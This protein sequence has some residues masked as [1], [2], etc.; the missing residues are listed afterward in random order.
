M[1]IPILFEHFSTVLIDHHV[2]MIILT[3]VRINE[4]C[5][6][7]LNYV[8]HKGD[9][10]FIMLEIYRVKYVCT[11]LHK[12]VHVCFRVNETIHYSYTY[13]PLRKAHKPVANTLCS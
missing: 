1:L 9:L 3:F 8:S 10:S 7:R 11:L 2:S 12:H 6:R 5:P 4:I 13:V